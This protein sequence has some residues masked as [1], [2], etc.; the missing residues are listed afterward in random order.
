M[1]RVFEVDTRELQAWK[2]ERLET[3]HI[4][5]PSTCTF[6]PCD[7]DD[8][9]LAAAVARSPFDSAQ[10][11]FVSWLGVTPYLDHATIIDTLDWIAGL[12]PQTDLVLTHAVPEACST[13]GGR[14]AE[15]IGLPVGTSFS[16]QE[17][18]DLLLDSG[19]GAIHELTAAEARARY[20]V[21]R[22]DG[23]NVD[24]NERSTWARMTR[25]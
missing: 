12:G 2:R 11:A 8:D 13:P 4:A 3:C 24:T 16:T 20:F 5:V 10:P 1:L 19:F 15:R 17:M 21:G 25:L 9:S 14:F 6:V 18:V 22:S 7:F 23:L